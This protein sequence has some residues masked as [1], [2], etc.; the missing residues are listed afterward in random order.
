MAR[1]QEIGAY[2]AYAIA[3]KYGYTGTEKEWIEEQERNRKAAAQSASDAS[4]AK[5][6]PPPC[7]RRR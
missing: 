5:A 7:R 6:A 1:E 4:D 3:V 2:S